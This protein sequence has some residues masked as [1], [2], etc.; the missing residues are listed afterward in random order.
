M[1]NLLLLFIL[2]PM[3]IFAQE[4]NATT[5]D[6]KY[7]EEIL[8][9]YCNPDAFHSEICSSWYSPEYESYQADS[10]IL[11]SLKASDLNDIQIKMVLA[12]WCHDSQRE[13]PRFMRILDDIEFDMQQLEIICVNSNKEAEDTEV[14]D[15]EID[16][17]PTIIFY[18]EG[19]EYGRIIETPSESLEKDF[20][21]ILNL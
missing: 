20:K 18:K 14:L 5:V 2:L 16:L 8:I 17:V 12:T 6:E 21:N 7:G 3:S 4:F 11:E 15:L 13:V 19:T 1:K 10:E 9:G